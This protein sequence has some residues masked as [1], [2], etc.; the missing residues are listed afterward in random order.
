MAR[1]GK[2]ARGEGRP[3]SAK[4]I[5]PV[6]IRVERYGLKLRNGQVIFESAFDG[7]TRAEDQQPSNVPRRSRRIVRGG[8][9]ARRSQR[10][11]GAPGAPAACD[12][13][14]RQAI[15]PF[16]LER[17][18]RPR[19][20]AGRACSAADGGKSGGAASSSRETSPA[21]NAAAVIKR[22]GEKQRRPQNRRSSLA[23]LERRRGVAS[24]NDHSSASA[25]SGRELGRRVRLAAGGLRLSGGARAPA[26]ERECGQASL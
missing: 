17:P 13:R 5:N 16:R 9:K 8:G 22:G 23:S 24:N 14:A 11:R 25:A 12:Q 3:C 7:S 2:A 1:R 6:S 10:P 21:E 15:G 20:A 4:L 19:A 26:H 18:R